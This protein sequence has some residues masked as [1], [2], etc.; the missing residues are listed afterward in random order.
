MKFGYAKLRKDDQNIDLQIDALNGF[1][2]DEIYQET[3]TEPRQNRKQLTELLGRLR[4]GDTLVVWRLD[5]LGKTIKQF[6]GLI[7]DFKDKGIR[8]VSLQENFDTSNLMGQFVYDVF[9]AMSQMELVTISERTKVGMIAA[10]RKGR[11]V[12]RKPK[13]NTIVESAL[14]MYFS[15]EC[16]IDHIIETTGLSRTTIYKYVREY[17]SNNKTDY[18]LE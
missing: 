13:E 15:S 1:G 6:F 4:A 9:C 5:R 16:S 18:S 3:V 14:T 12:G 10:K 17:K 7:K 11:L 2:V 8:L